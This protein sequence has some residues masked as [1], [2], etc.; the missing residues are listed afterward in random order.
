MS[1]KDTLKLLKNQQI[2]SNNIGYTFNKGWLSMALLWQNR[3]L[4]ACPTSSR[5]SVVDIPE[6]HGFDTLMLLEPSE[7]HPKTSVYNLTPAYTT[8]MDRNP[9]SATELSPITFCI[10]ISAVKRIR[11]KYLKLSKNPFQTHRDG[12]VLE[13]RFLFPWQ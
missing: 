2:I 13:L 4:I 12:H 8:I 6:K 7:Y 5:N 1:T 10:A 9:S 11:H 3:S